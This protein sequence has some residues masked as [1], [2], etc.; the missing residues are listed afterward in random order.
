MF[1]N[2]VTMVKLIRV[3]PAVENSPGVITPYPAMKDN[4]KKL[5]A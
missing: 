4:I 2:P 5:R 3:F 1:R